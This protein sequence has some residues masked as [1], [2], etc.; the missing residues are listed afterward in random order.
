MT[1]SEFTE[2]MNN[3][4]RTRVPF[5]F[6]VDFE[7][8]KPVILRASGID[9]GAIMFDINGISNVQPARTKASV[10][11]SSYPDSFETYK[12]KFDKVSHALH[13]GDSFLTNL[14]IKTRIT[15]PQDLLQLFSASK[16]RYKLYYRNEFIVFSPEP[17]VQIKDNRIHSFPM[18]G[19]IDATLPDAHNLV[20]K[21][22]KEL[23][24]HVTIVDLIRSDLSR[25]ASAVDVVR[26][27]YIDEIRS[28]RKNLLQVSSEITGVLPQ[29]YQSHLGD[30]FV[31]LLPAGSVSGAPKPRTVEIIR[32]AEGEKRGYFTGVFGYFDGSNLDSGVIIRYIE[33][34]GD[35][36]FYRSGGGIT[37]RS[38]AEAEYNEALD[39][40]YVPVD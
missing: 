25:V 15:T 17:F 35:D 29:D 22:E 16:A 32:D 30:I 11:I 34:D 2:H 19:T 3:L 4:G 36:Y 6:M 13:Y 27:R 18:K 24:E 20:I 7:M 28:S 21:S 37:T 8:E 9:A 26:F 23:A 5:L 38:Q 14:T 33:R 10:A 12:R 40:I 39:K 1:I 31:E